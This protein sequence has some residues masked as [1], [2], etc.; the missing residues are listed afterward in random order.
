[1][2]LSTLPFEGRELTSRRVRYTSCACFYCLHCTLVLYYPFPVFN[3]LTGTY[4]GHP[5]NI[6]IVHIPISGSC[7]HS[8]TRKYAVLPVLDCISA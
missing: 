7:K 6:V 1:M 2:N 8:N 4:L 3:L 5:S